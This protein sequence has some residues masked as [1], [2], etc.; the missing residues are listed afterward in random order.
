MAGIYQFVRRIRFRY[1]QF[2]A[3]IGAAV[4]V[5]AII[6]RVTASAAPGGQNWSWSGSSDGCLD[7]I[8]QDST[9]TFTFTWNFENTS[10][11]CSWSAPQP[12]EVVA[13]Q[14]STATGPVTETVQS[15]VES[16]KVDFG[17][18]GGYGVFIDE[19]PV[20]NQ[21]GGDS[22]GLGD[23]Y[24]TGVP[25]TVDAGPDQT[26][27]GARSATLNGTVSDATAQTTWT[28]LSGP[29]TATFASN[30][31]QTKVTVPVAS[32]SYVFQLS[33]T[34][35]GGQSAA[36]TVTIKFVFGRY[37]ALGD[38]YSAGVG[39]GGLPFDSD[40]GCL[41][42]NNAYPAVWHANHPDDM[43]TFVACS[44]GTTASIRKSQLKSITPGTTLI[45]I[46]AGGNDVWFVPVIIACSIPSADTECG[47]ATQLAQNQVRGPLARDLSSLLA[48]IRATTVSAGAPNARLVVF[49]YPHFFQGTGICGPTDFIQQRDINKTIDVLD[50]MIAKVAGASAGTTFDDIRGA[51]AGHE[52]CT[53]QPWLNGIGSS[54]DAVTFFHPNAAGQAQGYEAALAAITG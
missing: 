49:D 41:R 16:F 50:D 26:I 42:N 18:A 11:P 17:Q 54:R 10:I 46:T 22:G 34:D 28:E 47:A 53:K 33:A 9:F 45:T 37:V 19:Y 43:F 29:G 6:P 48:L 35:S 51:F 25:L 13:I 27:Y 3:V 21:P 30:T 15:A 24:I 44:S 20:G 52:L 23:I 4:L 36:A 1:L 39:S 12:G 14:Y 2:G 7:T 32:G 38:S 40:R 8:T 5:L 31:P